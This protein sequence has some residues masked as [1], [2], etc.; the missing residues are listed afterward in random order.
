[1]ARLLCIFSVFFTLST[2][3]AY[4]LACRII[5]LEKDSQK[6]ILNLIK[7]TPNIY[8]AEAL[9]YNT[10][11]EDFKFNILEVLKG[12][13][14]QEITISGVTVSSLTD[15]KLIASST[16]DFNSHQDKN[17]WSEL[18]LG[19]TSL[20][21]DCRLNPVFEVGQKYLILFKPPFHTKSFELIK[22]KQDHWYQ[23]VYNT[24][25]PPKK[26]KYI[27]KN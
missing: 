8:L 11:D 20:T 13:K 26:K 6:Y 21:A 14:K 16:R 10:T 9:S 5:P 18:L 24:L 1:M 25:Y 19:R 23:F 27:N 17:F 15:K 2:Y 12:E 22:S 4:S 3:S 7:S